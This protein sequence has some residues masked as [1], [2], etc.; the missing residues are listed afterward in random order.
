M[1]SMSVRSKIIWLTLE[2]VNGDIYFFNRKRL[3]LN[4]LLWQQH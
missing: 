3:E 4:K 2:I 1:G